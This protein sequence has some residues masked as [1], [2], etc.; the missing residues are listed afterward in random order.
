MRR[1]HATF[2]CNCRGAAATVAEQVARHEMGPA[3]RGNIRVQVNSSS[4][5]LSV[6]MLYSSMYILASTTTF[7]RKAVFKLPCA[8]QGSRSPIHFTTFL[9]GLR[10]CAL[11]YPRRG[12]S[13]E[14]R[15]LSAPIRCPWR[16]AFCGC[17]GTPS[18]TATAPNLLTLTCIMYSE[19]D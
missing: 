1:I 13:W 9:L 14:A 7:R 3:H 8:C 18:I 6:E 10:G 15:Y 2:A 16:Q 19:P 17:L 12:P 4:H 11:V 5:L